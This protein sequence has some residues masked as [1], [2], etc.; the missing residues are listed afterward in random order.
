MIRYPDE[1][2]APPLGF[3]M[4]H[5]GDVLRE[6]TAKGLAD[7]GLSPREYGVLWRLEHHG[8]LSQRE[9]GDLHRIDRTTVVA[10]VDHLELMGLVR[11][12]PDA[13][14]R[15]RHA[16][17]LTEPGRAR[18]GEASVVVRRVEDEFLAGVGRSERT[19]LRATLQA[20]LDTVVDP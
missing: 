18:L 15:R 16:L 5:L 14:D 17:E 3:L 7:L 4:S 8:P 12:A 9:L 20:I 6:R 13:D 2:P 10:V 11:R 1:M 19:Q